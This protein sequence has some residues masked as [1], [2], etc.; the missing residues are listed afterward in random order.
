MENRNLGLIR[1][2]YFLL[3][4][5]LV[6]IVLAS[7]VLINT[8]GSDSNKNELKNS[9]FVTDIISV[10]SF[11]LGISV[12]PYTNL[13]YVTNNQSGT[14]SVI[15]GDT[16]S[17]INTVKVG[18]GPA[19]ISVNS[20]TNMIYVANYY[21]DTVS[22]IDG[23]THVVI[24][25]IFV[26]NT[27]CFEEGDD[28]IIN[29]GGTNEETKELISLGADFFLLG[30]PLEFAHGPESF[31]DDNENGIWDPAEPFTDGNGN[32]VWDEAEPFTDCGIKADTLICE[33]DNNWNDNFGNG[34]WDEAEPLTDVNNNGVWD[35]AEQV[36]GYTLGGESASVSIGDVEI[37]SGFNGSSFTSVD[38]TK[39]SLVLSP[40]PIYS[41]IA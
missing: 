3:S 23:K 12:N 38:F 13:I 29:P 25:E 20:N 30:S 8:I 14:V 2:R 41:K 17:I 39:S 6:G 18:N 35:E 34:T 24:D 37:A 36:V 11:P 19:G 22:I 28:I 5:I 40:A 9:H 4:I 21:S 27:V 10:G 16:N 1:K 32:G 31:T 33:T 26:D 15:D 7:F